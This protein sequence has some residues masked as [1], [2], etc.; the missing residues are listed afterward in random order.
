MTECLKSA[1]EIINAYARGVEA[2]FYVGEC[3]EPPEWM[4]DSGRFAYTQGYD[5]GVSMYCST[6]DGRND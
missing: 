2:G 4:S 6:E 1:T 5:Q 3:A